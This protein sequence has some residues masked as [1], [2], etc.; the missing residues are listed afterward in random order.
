M[1]VLQVIL[2][3]VVLQVV[4]RVVV[5][6]AGVMKKKRDPPSWVTLFFSFASSSLLVAVC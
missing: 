5:L 3:V 2:R 1:V 4:L 6:H